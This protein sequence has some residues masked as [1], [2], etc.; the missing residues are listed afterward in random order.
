MDALLSDIKEK[1]LNWRKKTDVQVLH[2]QLSQAKH[3]LD[4]IKEDGET[5]LAEQ[6]LVGLWANCKTVEER[7]NQKR[8]AEA[9]IGELSGFDISGEQSKIAGS[10]SWVS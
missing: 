5:P 10:F 4:Q 2:N 8:S 1:D 7:T 6:K 9:R 3:V